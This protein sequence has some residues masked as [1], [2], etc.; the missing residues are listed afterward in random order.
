MKRIPPPLSPHRRGSR[1]LNLNKT[2]HY[3]ENGRPLDCEINSFDLSN[4]HLETQ[5]HVTQ[6]NFLLSQ[7]NTLDGV[8]VSL[9]LSVQERQSG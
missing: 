9:C 5:K 1:S 8:Y 2:D 3:H 7:G 6:R 4:H